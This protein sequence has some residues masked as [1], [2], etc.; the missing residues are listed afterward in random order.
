VI[1]R[2]EGGFTCFLKAPPPPT[3]AVAVVAATMAGFPRVAPIDMGL[4]ADLVS[5]IA[6]GPTEALGI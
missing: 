3:S 2:L 5:T 6:R 4:T 1:L